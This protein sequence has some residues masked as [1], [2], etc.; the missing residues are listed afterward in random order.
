MVYRD[1]HLGPGPYGVTTYRVSMESPGYPLWPEFMV[2]AEDHA[3]S[4]PFRPFYFLH[5]LAMA[6][7]KTRRHLGP[8]LVRLI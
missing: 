7:V 8:F 3:L 4:E 2:R 1:H 5:S 6:N